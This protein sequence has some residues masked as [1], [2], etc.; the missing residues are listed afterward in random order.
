MRSISRI[1][2][3]FA[4]RNLMCFAR[5]KAFSRVKPSGRSRFKVQSSRFKT[6]RRVKSFARVRNLITRNYTLWIG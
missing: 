2:C 5:V 6:A 3:I 1:M 4:N